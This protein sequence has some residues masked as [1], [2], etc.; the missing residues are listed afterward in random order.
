MTTIGGSVVLQARRVPD[1]EALV[2]GPRRWTW[3]ELDA[4]VAALAGSL[5]E[6]G[7]GPGERLAIVSGNT[8]EF[9]VAYFAALRLGAVVVPCNARLAPPELAHIVTDSGARIVLAG[10]QE[11]AAVDAAAS[12]LPR[13]AVVLDLVELAAQVP[14]A[15]I[16]YDR[17]GEDDHA[18][19]VYTSGTTGRPKGVLHTHRTAIWAA[20]AQIT[21]LGMKDGERYLHLPPLYHSGGV[22]YLDAMALLAGCNVLIPA[23]DPPA[24]LELIESEQIT[25]LLAVPTML[26]LLL[27]EPS[28]RARDTSSWLIGVFGAAPMPAHAI[29]ELLE[30]FPTVRFSQQCGQTEA[31]P[32][33]LYSTPE[34]VRERPDS[35]GHQAQTFMEARVVDAHGDPVAIDSV[36]ELCFRGPAVMKGY[37]NDPAATAETI[38]DG[39]LHTGDLVHVRDDGSMKLV[40]RMKDVII[41]GGRNVYSAEVEQ[42]LVKHP[43]IADCAVIGQPDDVWG[44]TVVAVVTPVPGATPTLEEL[45]RHCATLIADY[46]AP[47]MLRLAEIPRN[48]AGK[49]QK[50]LLRGDR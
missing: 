27:K 41:T 19:I 39:W 50:H 34:Q 31:G 38:S 47:R 37:W 12:E 42:A 35:S 13:P 10:V 16:L 36:G 40:D 26:Q 45:R 46:K 14:A 48:P 30:T 5:D 24:V 4:H 9:V 25:A 8:P 15:P 43:D 2:M 44:E 3:Q 22:V 1:R 11:R 33:G 29:E 49:I 6:M 21:S 17:A 32:T 28:A 18:L 7:L 23:F 20:L